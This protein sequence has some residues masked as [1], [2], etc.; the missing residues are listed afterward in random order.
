VTLGLLSDTPSALRATP[1]RVAR[2]KVI[3][4]GAGDCSGF[5]VTLFTI[6][7]HDPDGLDL[8]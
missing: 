8:P 4:A 2:E 1:P 3:E 5:F 6:V 7:S